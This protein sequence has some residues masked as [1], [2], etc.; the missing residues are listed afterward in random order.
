[1]A[2][3]S[4]QAREVLKKY[5]GY[6]SF[7]PLQEDIIL[8]ILQ[9]KDTLALLPTGGG[10]SICF[11]VPALVKEGVCIVVSPLIALMNDQV[12]NLK[13]HGIKA[14]AIHSGMSERETQNAFENCLYGNYKFLYLSPERLATQKFREYLKQLNISFIAIDEAH[15]ISQWGYDFR[16]PYLKIAEVRDILHYHVPFLALTATATPKVV[17]DIQEKLKFKKQNVFQKSFE[18]KNLAYIVLQEEDK[19]NRTLQILEKIKGCGIIY[20][21]SR[22]ETEKLAK[23]LKSNRISADFYHAGLSS[24]MREKKQAD[25]INDKTRIM[26][27]TNAFGMG[28]DK[29]D[30]RI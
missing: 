26:V 22:K 12:E 24:E 18:R 27:A 30:V 23:F 3:L 17:T 1:M 20:A 13:K 16:P 8:S 6:D 29:P 15:C 11:Q 14:V 10:K 5:W 7:R 25:W 2:H 21:R 19:L 4:R 9:N 28:I